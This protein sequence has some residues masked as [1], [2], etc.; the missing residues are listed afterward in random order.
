[1]SD[2]MVSL[3]VAECE[4]AY[5]RAVVHPR[6]ARRAQLKADLRLLRQPRRDT[7]AQISPLHRLVTR[8]SGIIAGPNRSQRA[9]GA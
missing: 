2:G 7:S 5:Q 3:Y 9:A 6:A 4:E 1:M 8:F